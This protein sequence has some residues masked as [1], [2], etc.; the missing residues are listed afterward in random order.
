M[1]IGELIRRYREEH[2]LTMG[3]FASLSGLSKGYISMLEKNEHPKTGQPIKPTTKT[4]LATAQAM[5]ITVPTLMERLNDTDTSIASLFGADLF[6]VG[7]TVMV[8]VVG[9]VRAGFGGLAFECDMGAETVSKRTVSGYDL[10][11]FFYLRVKGDSMEPRLY[12]GDLV[13]VRKQS[14]VDSG[15]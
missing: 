4:L 6:P 11:Q 14:S 9:V 8:P 13:L 5:H 10:S 12:E 15:S 1:T 3:E 7:E 2:K